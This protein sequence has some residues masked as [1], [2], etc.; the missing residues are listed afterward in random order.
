MRVIIFSV[1]PAGGSRQAGL[2][3]LHVL[4]VA[5]EPDASFELKPFDHVRPHHDCGSTPSSRRQAAPNTESLTSMPIV[6]ANV[7]TVNAS[8]YMQQLCKHWSHKQEA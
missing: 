2:R 3:M 6:S 4:G 8:K 5:V 7:P 1:S